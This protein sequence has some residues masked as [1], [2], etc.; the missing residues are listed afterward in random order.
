MTSRELLSRELSRRT[1]YVSDEEIEH[2]L[3]RGSGFA[4]GKLRIAALYENNPD[5]KTAQEFLKEEYGTGGHSHTYLKKLEY[6][7]DKEGK[8]VPVDQNG[9]SGIFIGKI[10]VKKVH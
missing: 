5:P 7:N 9:K 6:V 3:R 2:A 4:G 10:N 8:P 1:R